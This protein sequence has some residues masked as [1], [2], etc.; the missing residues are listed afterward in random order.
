MKLQQTY[1]I[2]VEYYKLEPSGSNASVVADIFG[3]TYILTDNNYR[4]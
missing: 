2:I 4:K 1:Y 3:A